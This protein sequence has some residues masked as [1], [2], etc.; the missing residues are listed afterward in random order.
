V[1]QHVPDVMP[2][3]GSTS[4]ILKAAFSD[5]FT[6]SGLCLTMKAELLDSLACLSLSAA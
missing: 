4:T 2:L 5:S 1:L 3:R 6:A